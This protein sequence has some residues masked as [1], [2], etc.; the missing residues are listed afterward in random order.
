MVLN[1]DNLESTSYIDKD[2]YLDII[3]YK[4]LNNVLNDTITPPEKCDS[5]QI[6]VLKTNLNKNEKEKKFS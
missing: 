6:S 5:E 4:Q 3:K 2:C 1:F